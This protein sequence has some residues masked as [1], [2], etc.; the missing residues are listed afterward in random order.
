MSRYFIKVSG[1]VQGVGF[2][3]NAH[4]FASHFNLTG[5]IKNCDDGTVEMEVQGSENDISAFKIKIQEG[6]RYIKVKNIYSQKIEN[7]N[8][9]K[10]FRVVY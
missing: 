8:G 10:A 3:F 1:R 4:Y 6:N 2:R 7:I 9:D 5:W